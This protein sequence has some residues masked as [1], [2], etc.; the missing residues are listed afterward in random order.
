MP[1]W[2][3]LEG[4]VL[5]GERRR[6]PWWG[7]RSGCPWLPRGAAACWHMARPQPAVPTHAKW[8]VGTSGS[9]RHPAPNASSCHRATS[10]RLGWGVSEPPQEQRS[11]PDLWARLGL[12]PPPA[13]L[14]RGT[15]RPQPAGLLARAMSC[16][17][18][19]L[20][21]AKPG[22][23]LPGSEGKLCPPGPQPRG[24]PHPPWH[25][26][27]VPPG[28]EPPRGSGWVGGA[29]LN[30]SRPSSAPVPTC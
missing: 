12:P 18:S 20:P 16:R 14:A 2:V 26:P 9:P 22:S 15:R 19:H 28:P 11:P 13:V 27:R 17:W 24:S 7:R 5:R 21:A 8:L 10:P 29:P 4:W 30:G 3:L 6:C 1:G 25:S 23:A